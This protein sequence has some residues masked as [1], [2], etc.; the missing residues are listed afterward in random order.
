MHTK[1]DKNALKFTKKHKQAKI[2]FSDQ[3]LTKD[4]LKKTESFIS[5]RT[6]KTESLDY[7]HR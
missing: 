4:K 2:E 1:I 5:K 7:R 6:R 3:K